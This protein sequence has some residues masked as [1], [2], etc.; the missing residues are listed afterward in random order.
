MRRIILENRSY[1]ISNTILNSI[2]LLIKKNRFLTQYDVSHWTS[3]K[4]EWKHK[5]I[6]NVKEDLL[7]LAK[8]ERSYGI[9]YSKLSSDTTFWWLLDDNILES[10][11]LWSLIRYSTKHANNILWCKP[12]EPKT[13]PPPTIKK[14]PTHKR[15]YKKKSRMEQTD[16]AILEQTLRARKWRSHERH[17]L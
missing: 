1:W 9:F 15:I 13:P 11:S 4:R 6:K 10:F 5:Q 3:L 12:L 7:R 14:T 17:I 16:K 2:F 8:S